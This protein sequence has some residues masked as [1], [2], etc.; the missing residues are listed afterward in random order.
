[1]C[2]IICRSAISPDIFC[3]LFFSTPFVS[4]HFVDN[5]TRPL[6]IYHLLR[7]FLLF[8]SFYFVS[9]VKFQFSLYPL[10]PWLVPYAFLSTKLAKVWLH[11]DTSFLCVFSCRIIVTSYDIWNAREF[12]HVIGNKV[13]GWLL[14]EARIPPCTFIVVTYFVDFDAC[15]LKGSRNRYSL[16][17]SDIH[18][19]SF[20]DFYLGSHYWYLG[21]GEAF[22]HVSVLSF[23]AC[24]WI[25]ERS[26]NSFRD[27][28][29]VVATVPA[30]EEK[31]RYEPILWGNNFESESV[32]SCL[33]LLQLTGEVGIFQNEIWLS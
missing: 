3:H 26:N 30:A 15:Q 22:L 7:D 33:R 29:I 19:K 8:S 13:D 24:R 25:D 32:P 9:R 23:S 14:V 10:A 16:I 5:S 21:W 2:Q 31:M 18:G 11:G 1:M 12:A 20:G 27:I 6:S 4:V 28:L 17:T